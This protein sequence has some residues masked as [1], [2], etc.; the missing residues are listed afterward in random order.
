MHWTDPSVWVNSSQY[1]SP[2]APS[3]TPQQN[4]AHLKLCRNQIAVYPLVV[5]EYFKPLL[6]HICQKKNNLT[7]CLC[8]NHF[9]LV[10]YN[11][12]INFKY[13]FCCCFIPLTQCLWNRCCHRGHL[14]QVGACWEKKPAAWL[15][16][17]INV[18]H[19]CIIITWSNGLY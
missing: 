8:T 2:L 14:L 6:C 19:L 5:C 13:E 12:I 4:P 10:L 18:E 3:A 7:T 11:A 17:I 1:T 9:P 16:F 15:C